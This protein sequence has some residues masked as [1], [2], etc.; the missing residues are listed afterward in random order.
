[1]ESNNTT[2]G[3]A[4]KT[5]RCHNYFVNGVCK[6]GDNCEYLHIY[7]PHFKTELCRHY[8]NYGNCNQGDLCNFIHQDAPSEPRIK[9][10]LCRNYFNYGKCK[11]GDLC[12]FIHQNASSEKKISNLQ[13]KNRRGKKN[14]QTKIKKEIN[15]YFNEINEINET[16]ETNETN[17]I[18]KRK[19]SVS[20]TSTNALSISAISSISS[21]SS[22]SSKVKSTYFNKSNIEK[23]VNV[24]RNNDYNY[25]NKLNEIL[26]DFIKMMTP[27]HSL[28]L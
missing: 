24:N 27:I 25:D 28:P 1:M 19:T 26:G 5:L 13:T 18:N 23:Y 9:T 7:P 17:E 14:P 4:K 16:N 2:V 12:N 22:S 11:H 15:P 10:E 6:L 21:V 20:S 3:T 8:L